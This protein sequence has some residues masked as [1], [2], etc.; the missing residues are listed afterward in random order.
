VSTS[1][2]NTV[3]VD[4]SVWLCDYL[5]VELAVPRERIDPDEPMVTYGL[6]SLTAA[7]VLVAVQQRVGFEVDPNC[8]WDFPTATRFAGY[9]ADRIAAGD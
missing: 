8:L 5:A 2:A 1:S 3:Q 4:L 6:D 7:A 9:L